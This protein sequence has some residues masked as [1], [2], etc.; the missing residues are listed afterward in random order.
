[1]TNNETIALNNLKSR[2][3]IIIHS[4]DKGGK[5]VVMNRVDYIQACKI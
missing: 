3:D 2:D 5:V 1:M 4:A